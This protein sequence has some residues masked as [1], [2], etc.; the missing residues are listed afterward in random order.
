MVI[1]YQIWSWEG[2]CP[3]IP[4]VPFSHTHSIP[5][6]PICSRTLKKKQLV[7]WTQVS[8]HVCLKPQAKFVFHIF[9]W[10]IE[11]QILKKIQ[12]QFLFSVL[13][14]VVELL[15]R[16]CCQLNSESCF[17]SPWKPHREFSEKS[18]N[19]LTLKP[20]ARENLSTPFT[21]KELPRTAETST[22]HR[23]PGGTHQGKNGRSR[24][25]S[26]GE[27]Q[28]SLE[29]CFLSKGMF[30]TTR[31]LLQVGMRSKRLEMLGKGEKE[32]C[33]RCLRDPKLAHFRK[34]QQNRHSKSVGTT[35]ESGRQILCPGCSN[36]WGNIGECRAGCRRHLEPG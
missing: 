10:K 20:G 24:G 7:R 1:V 25:L 26:G 35:L 31:E 13:N 27:S 12:W 17:N 36:W 21:C 22:S 33:A 6:T 19:L 3:F 4:N 9:L 34:C 2:I 30:C 32:R 5:A 18:Q 28:K 16:M 23:N 15:S 29:K 11:K 8:H 14:T